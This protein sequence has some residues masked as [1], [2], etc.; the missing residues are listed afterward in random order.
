MVAFCDI[1]YFVHVKQWFL[2]FSDHER[3]IS[4]VV[5]EFYCIEVKQDQSLATKG[6]EL[7]NWDKWVCLDIEL[8]GIII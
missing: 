6:I 8:I 7:R 2:F 1:A 3:M 4:S 5:W